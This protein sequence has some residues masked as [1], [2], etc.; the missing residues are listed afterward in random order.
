MAERE[1]FYGDA[2][3]IGPGSA[4]RRY[5]RNGNGGRGTLVVRVVQ[6][7]EAQD[8]LAAARVVVGDLVGGLR[9]GEARRG[10]ARRGEARRGEARRG[11]ARRDDDALD[12]AEG[13]AEPEEVHL[14]HVAAL[15]H[16]EAQ[17]PLCRHRLLVAP[18]ALLPLAS[19]D[20][21]LLDRAFQHLTN[22]INAKGW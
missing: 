22:A 18:R 4:G 17:G 11:E 1:K 8:A 12:D 15:D 13:I 9:R 5:R 16:R 2:N 21:L 6:P 7:R 10:E 3:P 14:R 20:E 19:R